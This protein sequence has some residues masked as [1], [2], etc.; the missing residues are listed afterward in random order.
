MIKANF[1][2]S[3]KSNISLTTLEKKID[4][5]L[6]KRF[7]SITKNATIWI[8]ELADCFS[9]PE[10]SYNNKIDKT[11]EFIAKYTLFDNGWKVDVKYTNEVLNEG[12]SYPYFIFSKTENSI[13][14]NLKRLNDTLQQHKNILVKY[15]TEIIKTKLNSKNQKITVWFKDDGLYG[16]VNNIYTN[17][18]GVINSELIDVVVKHFEQL[19]FYCNIKPHVG[20]YCNSAM[21]GYYDITVSLK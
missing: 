20:T 5:L 9:E 8:H 21:S 4:L 7:N 18:E 13:S 19:G 15:I 6:L 17:L 12:S 10:L 14:V 11:I 1:F 16:K 3:D 2:D